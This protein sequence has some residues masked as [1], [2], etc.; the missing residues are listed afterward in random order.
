MGWFLDR[1]I[2]Y[3]T[4]PSFQSNLFIFNLNCV[5]S[6]WRKVGINACEKR[7]FKM[8]QLRLDGLHLSAQTPSVSL[9]ESIAHL[10]NSVPYSEV[11]THST[12]Y[13]RVLSEIFNRKIDIVDEKMECRKRNC[14]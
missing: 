3:I 13:T 4:Q 8:M 2:N 6:N 5:M 7:T 12:I 10:S 11:D 9:V 14:S 1:L